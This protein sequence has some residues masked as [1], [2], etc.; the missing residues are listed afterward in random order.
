MGALLVNSNQNEAAGEEFKKAIAADPNYADAQFQYGLYLA[1]KAT[2]DPSGKIIV[3]P[4]TIEALQKY[5][6][7]KP[8]GPMAQTAKDMIAQLGGTLNVNIT[9]PNAASKKKK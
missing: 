4:G 7:L 6:E 5:I 1:A 3:Q 8:D 9:T 2:P